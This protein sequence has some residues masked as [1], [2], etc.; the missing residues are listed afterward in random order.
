MLAAENA[1]R[2]NLARMRSLAD[3]GLSVALTGQRAQA[4]G[5]GDQVKGMVRAAYAGD[6][7]PELVHTLADPTA[8]DAT[9][10]PPPIFPRG[11]W[12]KTAWRS[13]PSP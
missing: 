5:H 13:G 4:L 9:S 3:R 10:M 11:R 6:L 2:A 12:P 7:S 8:G 1:D